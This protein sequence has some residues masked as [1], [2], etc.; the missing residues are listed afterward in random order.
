VGRL[1]LAIIVPLSIVV[2]GCES[3]TPSNPSNTTVASVI[4]AGTPPAAG[5]SSQFT[6]IAVRPDGSSESVTSKATWRSSNT[7]VATVSAG[8]VVTAVTAGSV[9]ISA[10]YANTKGSLTF[11]V[12]SPASSTL[13]GTV[14]DGVSGAPLA[15]A[16]VT[17]TEASGTNKSATTDADGHYSIGGLAG[18]DVTVTAAAADY[19]SA[20]K[21]IRVFGD[22]T[23]DFVLPRV[24]PCPSLGFDSLQVHGSQF[25]VYSACGFTITASTSNW[26]VST[27]YGHPPPFVQFRSD[28]GR[29]TIGEIL[30]RGAGAKFR[31]RSVDVYSSTTPIPYVITGIADSVTVLSIQDTQGNTSGN[32]A[33]IANPQPATPIDALVIRLTNPAAPCCPNPMGIDNILLSR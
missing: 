22:M 16:T 2:S 20:S 25:S 27:S 33:T 8:G 28:A 21:S 13:R 10:T 15:S 12:R 31:F 7:S 5:A 3:S 11:T 6:A 30:V 19:A 32:F 18:G 4:V 17:A 24:A 26:T 1:R 9:E 23:V 29:S 14:A